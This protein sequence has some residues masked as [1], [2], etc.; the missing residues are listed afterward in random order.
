MRKASARWFRFLILAA[1][2]ARVEAA[3]PGVWIEGELPT[4]ATF[5]VGTGSHALLSGGR[6]LVRNDPTFPKNA[7][8]QPAMIEADYDFEAAQAGEYT[9]WV[10]LGYEGVRAPLAWRIDDGAWHELPTTNRTTNVM[11]LWDFCEVAWT[12]AGQ[13]PLTAGPHR[14]RVRCQQPGPDGRLLM[15]LDSFAF[16]ADP[17]WRPEG[18]LQP[19]AAY[20]EAVDLEAGNRVFCLDA[21]PTDPGQ[22]V[23]LSLDGLWQ[24]ARYDD[25]DMEVG[26]YDAVTNLPAAVQETLHWRGLAVPGDAKQR[27]DLVFGHRLV[28]QTRVDVPASYAGRSFHLRLSGTCWIASVFVNG[29]FVGARKSVLVPWEADLTAAMRPGEVNTIQVVIKDH[30]YAIDVNSWLHKKIASL[31]AC[32]TL[33]IGMAQ[34]RSYV[35][36]VYPTN[37]GEGKG[38]QAGIVLPVTLVVA[39]AA[40]VAD[41]FV[42]PDV[43]NRRLDASVTVQ[44][45]G[46]AAATLE[47]SCDAV[48]EASGRVEKT[49]AVQTVAIP[50]GANRALEF[51]DAWADA[52]LWWPAEA[53]SE[54]PD[55]YLL[56]TTVRRDGVVV[57]VRETRFG[58]REVAIRGKDV[59]LNGIPW[60]FWNWLGVPEA[61]TEEEWLEGYHRQKS[62]FHRFSAEA[63]ELWATREAAL[64]FHD[65]HGVP[66]RLSTCINGMFVNF[67]LGN[68][69]VW[70]NFSEHVEQVVLAYRNHPSVLMYSLENEL[71]FVTGANRFQPTYA[72]QEDR[73]AG[74]CRLAARLDP[75]RPSFGDGAGDC[76]GQTPINCQHYAWPQGDL[77][78]SNNYAFAWRPPEP[79]WAVWR[80]RDALRSA[81]S[82]HRLWGWD[83]QRPL[84]AGEEFFYSG[85]AASIAW[86]GGPD[87]YRSKAEADIAAGRYAS[88][89][90]QGC[91]WQGVAGLFPWALPLPGAVDSFSPRAVF[92][93]EWNSVFEPE[94][95]L[96]RTIKVFNDGRR[97][98]PLTLRWSLVLDGRER[99][100]GRKTYALEAGASAQDELVVELPSAT[101]RL[102]GSL[103]LSLSAG[104]T[105]VFADD[106]PISLLPRT[107]AWPGTPPGALAVFD[108][109]G[110]A[111]HWLDTHKAVRKWTGDGNDFYTAVD[112]PSALPAG[113]TV[114]LVG[115]NAL[116]VTNKPAWSAVLRDFVAAGKTAIVL[117]QRHP[118][119]EADLPVPDIRLASDVAGKPLRD[120][121]RQ[122]GGSS[123]R[124]AFPVALAH[125]A[126][127]DLRPRDFFTWG[128]DEYVYRLSYATP[129]GGAIALV[130]GGTDLAQ[131]P[132]M[133]IPVGSGSLL[134]S[135]LL[136]A[137]KLGSEPVADRLLANLLSW[138]AGRAGRSP[139]RTVVVPDADAGLAP[140]L[141]ETGLKFSLADSVEAGLATGADVLLV[142]A[143]AAAMTELAGR[144]GELRRACEAGRW[145]MLCNVD[146]V[147]L[148]NLNRLVGFDHR[149]RG[150][151]QEKVTLR[152]RQDPLLLGLSD[153]D[154]SMLSDEY[155][156]SWK[157]LYWVS[158]HVFTEVVDGEDVASFAQ[159]AAPELFNIANG[160]TADDFWRYILYR[161][162]TNDAVALT[163]D[164]PE[165]FVGA[166]IQSIPAYHA[167]KDIELAFDGKAFP[168][169]LQKTKDMQPLAFKPQQATSVEI[170][171][172]GHYPGASSQP[173]VQIDNFELLRAWPPKVAE[174]VVLL[175]QPGG[176]VKYPIGK[177]GIVLNQLRRDE[178]KAAG[179]NAAANR[180]KKLAIY[181]SLLRNMGAAFET[182]PRP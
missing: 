170:R 81:Q 15:G 114:L 3:A 94:T 8:G 156:A 88:I 63:D 116:T 158:D 41:V 162:C 39:G 74:L 53:A 79:D 137:G 126:F 142:N 139:G 143:T 37:F 54:R 82:R 145:V 19:G 55:C 33:P 168:F 99:G 13:L 5:E 52:K 57:D 93:R 83:G 105:E 152:A 24:V 144:Q 6:W 125:P 72:E 17:T 43:A 108:P 167:L 12:R 132:M 110:S 178:G 104:K 177:G 31:D 62:R 16:V 86:I 117:E 107:R 141:A 129:A 85:N 149:M 98:D 26:T 51:G 133:E 136:V 80:S 7:A 138:A 100:S 56:R 121:F 123:G 58:F 68:P 60:R 164:R 140:F 173:L 20:A 96:R 87:V 66:G 171:I 91:R 182:T 165:T 175:T 1:S 101:Q 61:R 27:P 111:R 179:A 148:Q 151:R 23:S 49:F 155:A 166:G 84:I 131:T 172:K 44:N 157:N 163:F 29:R 181:G 102:D 2:A 160:L 169:T 47:V 103:R 42:R 113:A 159:F 35:A 21:P 4:R 146:P 161:N 46:T 40:H 120:E 118:L 59:L 150:F 28:Y 89:A 154:L 32:R 130:Q 78:P 153:R 36:P 64:A 14:L 180:R 65:R 97:T 38:T 77:T 73:F 119:E 30:Y 70:S 45:S 135:Q 22:R 128:G 92:V 134:L 18:A 109:E 75:T 122:A 124:I 106:K 11:S 176:L 115:A 127:R 95:E 90:I 50:S 174:R 76:R 67:D 48:H 71:L 147:G 10:R 9:F 34:N 112:E 69:L 25:P